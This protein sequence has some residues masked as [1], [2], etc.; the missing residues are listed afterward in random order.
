LEHVHR[1]RLSLERLVELTSAGPARVF[2]IAGKGRLAT[3][4]D[5]DL[6]LVDLAAKR[7][8]RQDWIRSRCGWTPYA[9]ARVNGWPAATVVRGH[10]V[11]RA[12]R[13]APLP[14]GRPV[15]FPP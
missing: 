11:M 2:G 12:G 4:C 14:V 5:A 6:T 10:L 7:G 3:G 13:L 1:G 9:G 8:I 15:S